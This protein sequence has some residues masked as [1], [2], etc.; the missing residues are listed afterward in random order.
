MNCRILNVIRWVVAGLFVFSLSSSS[1]AA[2]P[3]VAQDANGVE[4]AASGFIAAFNNLDMAAF[5]TCFTEDA[6][7]IHPPS[8]PPRTFPTRLQGKPDIERT[9][10]VVFDQIRH[11][12]GRATAPFQNIQ[13]QD[14]L[15]QQ[16]DGFAVV[17]FH[18]GTETRRGRR[19]LV[20]RRVASEWKI[21]HLHASLFEAVR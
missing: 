6:T 8:G 7:I 1:R 9:F 20:F 11:A 4:V 13:P 10:R 3:A 17:T 18:L 21:V 14:L 15:I 2:V 19:T 5:L 12:S 16:F